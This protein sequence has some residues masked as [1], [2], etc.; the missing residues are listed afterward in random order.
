MPQASCTLP[1]EGSMNRD[2]IIT[3]LSE[4]N[5]VKIEELFRRA[6]TVR[7][8]EFSNKIF[9]Y[10]FVYFS[11][12][13]RNN[14]NFC[15]YRNANSISRYRKTESEIIAI[16]ELLAKSGV[17]LID[18][19]M[20]EDLAY[21]KEHFTTVFDM[22]KVIKD[23]TGLPVMISPGLVENAWID[24]FSELDT[25]WY[26]LYQETHNREL[27]ARL[28]AGQDYDERMNAKLYARDRGM[29]IEEGILTGVGEDLEDIADSLLEMGKI[30]A[31]QVRVMSFVPQKGIPM[32]QVKKPEPIQELKIIALLRLLYPKALI[33]A[34]LDIDGIKGLEDRINAGASVVTSIIPPRSGLAGVAQ[35]SMDV[36]EGGRT[37]AEAAGI[38]KNMGLEPA[39]AEEYRDYLTTLREGSI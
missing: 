14:C 4:D 33:P 31:R 13:C 23:R 36:D 6:R 1:K 29:L 10:G 37:V 16:S 3:I 7:A 30:G 20:G 25:E 27:F 11:T 15:Y 26:A 8:R 2:E 9:L 19:T 34:S 28:R 32:E 39:S 38:L 24:R 12:W 22:I 17:N 5:P 21:H 35:N 18:L